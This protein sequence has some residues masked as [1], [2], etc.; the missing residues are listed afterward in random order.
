VRFEQREDPVEV[1]ITA[2][3][4]YMSGITENVFIVLSEKQTERALP[5]NRPVRRIPANA[6][7]AALVI[8]DK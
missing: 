3:V 1:P 2:T 7:K 8:I 4:T 6:D 5:L